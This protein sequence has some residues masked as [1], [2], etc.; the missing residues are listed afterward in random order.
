MKPQ[1]RSRKRGV[2]LTLQGFQ[3]LQ[4]AKSQSESCENLDKHYTHQALA[5]RTG[6]D[7]DTVAKVFACEVG[8]DQQTL[9][10]CFRAFN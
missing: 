6:L 2:I 9:K 3:K 10:S 4:D 5:I 8:V 7:P 1:Q